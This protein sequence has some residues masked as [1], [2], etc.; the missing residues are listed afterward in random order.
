MIEQLS[1]LG[2]DRVVPLRTQRSVVH[3]RPQKFE[4]FQK[5]AIES[6]KQSGRLFL[7]ELAEMQTLDQ[8]MDRGADL[9][10]ALDARGET[11]D[12]DRAELGD[13][14]HL[15]LMIGPEG[16][17]TDQELSQMQA[18]GARPW[19]VGPTVLRI[20]TAAVA[21]AAIA[22]FMAIAP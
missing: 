20:E 5:A 6:A 21:A 17:F 2:V 3:P 22:R 12:L 7:M 9:T 4:R 13:C 16:G 15:R 8:V 18:A 10:L 1:Q 14:Q 11:G 19:T